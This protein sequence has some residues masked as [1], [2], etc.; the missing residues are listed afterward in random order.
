MEMSS[1]DRYKRPRLDSGAA[2]VAAAAAPG[3]ADDA[4]ERAASAAGAAADVIGMERIADSSEEAASVSGTATAIAAAAAAATASAS[5]PLITLKSTA[6]QMPPGEIVMRLRNIVLQIEEHPRSASLCAKLLEAE[7]SHFL[8]LDITATSATKD[9]I[10]NHLKAIYLEARSREAD[11]IEKEWDKSAPAQVAQIVCEAAIELRNAILHSTLK[12]VKSDDKEA[13][14]GMQ[15]YRGFVPDVQDPGGFI[16]AIIRPEDEEF[17][18]KCIHLSLN[19]NHPVCGVGNPGIGKTSTTLYLLQKL[20][21]GHKVPVVYTIREVSGRDIFYEFVPVVDNVTEKV[22]NIAVKVY[23]IFAYNKAVIPSMQNEDACFVVDPGDFKGSCAATGR[24][25]AARFI[26]NASN[27]QG[28]WGGGNFTKLRNSRSEGPLGSRRANK[29]G[30]LVYASLWT[31]RQ[32]LLAKPHLA[33]I[34]KLSD[35]EVLHRFRLVGGSLRDIFTVNEVLFKQDVETALVGLARETVRELARGVCN[36]AL[37]AESPSSVLI[38]IGPDYTIRDQF[39]P[40]RKITLK[41]DYVA[42]ALAV[43]FLHMSWFE[44]LDEANAGNRG[45]LFESYIRAKF[46]QAPVVFTKDD[47][48]QSLRVKPAVGKKK[49]YEAVR[50]PLTVGSKRTLVRVSDMLAAVHN[51]VTKQCIYYSRDESEPFIDMIYRVDGGFDAIQ[52][53]IAR[54]HDAESKKLEELVEG[55]GF[56]PGETLRLIYAVP[57]SRYTEFKT[58]PVNPLLDA[59][60]AK[61]ANVTIY[62]VSVHD[63]DDRMVT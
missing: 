16:R 30:V 27:D 17:W 9:A 63:D 8:Q 37:S 20:I 62:H 5:K 42:E 29:E 18:E 35:N 50:K 23:E 52:A 60:S 48:R 59:D 31:A 53:T 25:C 6:N 54:E 32:V 2:G 13:S 14:E 19:K 33:A 51:D 3:A 45:N 4:A 15:V 10:F 26:M 57:K 46:S 49:N 39:P 7:L 56:Q 24:T 58:K 38:G 21:V 12:Y 22:T 61:S 55:L 1:S 44:L 34:E 41:S 43:K 11:T 40:T 36:F 47:A 28:H